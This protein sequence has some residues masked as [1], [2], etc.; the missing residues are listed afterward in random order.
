[1]RLQ[2]MLLGLTLA[3]IGSTA[4]AA[5]RDDRVFAACEAARDGELSLPREVVSIDSGT[6]DT[7]G[8]ARIQAVL[9]A[10]LKALGGIVSANVP[11]LAS[12]LLASV[13]EAAVGANSRQC[14]R[15]DGS[16]ALPNNSYSLKGPENRLRV[17]LTRQRPTLLPRGFSLL[18]GVSASMLALGGYLSPVA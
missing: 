11:S 3:A 14:R 10:R 8:A 15:S 9:G 7:M 6:G 1:M 5:G 16:R 18:V 4:L 12:P 2:T 13:S 17:H